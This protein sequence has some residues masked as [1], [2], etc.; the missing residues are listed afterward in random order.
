VVQ[1]SLGDAGAV[2]GRDPASSVFG[3]DGVVVA[4]RYFLGDLVELHFGVYR[5]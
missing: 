2:L 3:R 4:V 5:C 1:E